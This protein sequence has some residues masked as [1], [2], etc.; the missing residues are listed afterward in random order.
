MSNFTYKYL[1][2]SL[3]LFDVSLR[4]GLQ[5]WKR[6]PSLNEKKSILHK[7]SK[8]HN[9]NKIEVGSIVSDKILPQFKDSIE[10][11]HHTRKIYD[12]L[13]P[14]LLVPNIKMQQKALHNNIENMS[15]ITS[16]SENFQKKNTNMNLSET[17]NQIKEMI[18]YTP[19]YKKLYISCINECPIDGLLD[20]NMVVNEIIEYI[21]LPLHEIC[22]S[23]TCGTLTE[24]SLNEILSIL[25][26]VMQLNGIPISRLSLHLHKHKN[27][28]ETKKIIFKCLD[29]YIYNFDVSYLIGGGCSVTM[30]ENNI[31]DNL[32]YNDFEFLV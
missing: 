7:I 29:N 15:F 12:H 1:N 17:K 32:H 6:I 21:K 18:K 13:T 9:V 8:F 3:K 4:D 28:Y 5:T 14:Y 26:P 2:R 10:L 11:Y 25:L 30:N 20:N 19:G 27:V 22:I 16:V 23:D 24:E 31:N